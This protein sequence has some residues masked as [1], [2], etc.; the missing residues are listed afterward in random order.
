MS[1]SRRG[2]LALTALPL[3][4]CFRPMLAEDSVSSDLRGRVA[5]PQVDDRFGYF[6]IQGLEGRLGV[7]KSPQYRLEVRTDLTERGIAVT[8][9]N[10]ITRLT[11]TATARWQ[12][13]SIET[14]APVIIDV[15]SAQSGYNATD[16]LFATRQI[17]LDVERRLARDLGERI[18]RTVLARAEQLSS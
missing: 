11:L 9:N 10:E 6:L 3:A 17:R 13:V 8:Q 7:P 5:M 15:T 12:L 1:W 18:A 2:V 16:S 4:G 14:S